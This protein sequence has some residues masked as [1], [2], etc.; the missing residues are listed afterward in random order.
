MR[1]YAL[2]GAVDSERPGRSAGAEGGGGCS[3]PRALPWYRPGG[4]SGLGKGARDSG[5]RVP[6]G[7][8]HGAARARAGALQAREHLCSAMSC[9]TVPSSTSFF[10]MKS[11]SSPT[12][13]A[14][15]AT[16]EPSSQ[17]IPVKS[18]RNYIDIF[19]RFHD[20]VIDRYVF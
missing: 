8:V 16:F 13:P 1:L 7:H 6:R 18:R 19:T 10:A 11:I 15:I 9:R 3:L 12:A 14:A 20:C 17:I 4:G 5:R 2:S